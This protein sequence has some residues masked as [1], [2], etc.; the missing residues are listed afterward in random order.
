V[1]HRKHDL[2]SVS[3]AANNSQPTRMGGTQPAMLAVYEGT[4]DPVIISPSVPAGGVPF[5]H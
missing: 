2:T 3:V 5:D 4:G 1:T